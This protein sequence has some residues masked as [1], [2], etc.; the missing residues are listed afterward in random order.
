MAQS[1]NQNQDIQDLVNDKNHIN[2]IQ[3]A[4]CAASSYLGHLF[5]IVQIKAMAIVTTL[6]Q[7]KG[8]MKGT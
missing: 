7:F 8:H 4:V 2:Y 3:N 1:A 5:V 6:R